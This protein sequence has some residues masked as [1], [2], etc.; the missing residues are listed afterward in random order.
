MVRLLYGWACRRRRPRVSTSGRQQRFAPLSNRSVV[1]KYGASYDIIR[2]VGHIEEENQRK[3][4]ANMMLLDT[5]LIPQADKLWDV[6]R[7][8]EAV[9]QG[10]TTPAAIGT[11][12]GRIGPRQGLY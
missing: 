7:V 4:V 11:Y 9:Q 3:G 5:L 6:A 1:V 12:I 10:L 8:P 2:S